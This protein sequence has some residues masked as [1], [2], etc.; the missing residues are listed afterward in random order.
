MNGA[1]AQGK[2]DVSPAYLAQLTDF[3]ESNPDDTNILGEEGGG[4]GFGTITCAL[5]ST[6]L[7][8]AGT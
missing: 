4:H 6:Q 7:S 5:L 2:Q 1:C 3:L 8:A